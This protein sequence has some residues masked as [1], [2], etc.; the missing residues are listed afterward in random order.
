MWFTETAWPPIAIGVVLAFAL[1]IAW[2]VTQRSS[3]LV[4]ALGLALACVGVYFA[5]EQIVTEAEKVEAAVYEV[6]GAFRDDDLEK[7]LSYISPSEEGMRLAVTAA[8]ALY[9]VEDDLRITDV[10]V[11][12][13][14]NDTLA[15]SRFRANATISSRKGGFRGHHPTHWELTWRKIGGEWKITDYQR[16]HVVTGEPIGTWSPQ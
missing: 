14:A 5:E 2:N 16:L 15:V 10:R 7:T 6:T 8:N 4:G 11:E 1:L 3:Y 12:T 9:D 13:R